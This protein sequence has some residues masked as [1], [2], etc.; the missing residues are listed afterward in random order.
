VVGQTWN[1]TLKDNGVKFFSGTATTKA[2]SGSFEVKKFTA[3]NPG[4]DTIKGSA[5]NPSTGETC[6]GSLSI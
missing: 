3:N 4:T 6:D 5:T 1:V 2:P